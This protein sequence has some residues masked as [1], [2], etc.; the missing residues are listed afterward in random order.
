MD[1]CAEH[2]YIDPPT[3][4]YAIGRADSACIWWTPKDGTLNDTVA[5]EIH[6]FRCDGGEWKFKGIVNAEAL[7]KTQFVVRNLS[8]NKQYKFS[9]KAV[10]DKGVGFKM[11]VMSNAVMVEQALPAGWFRFYSDKKKKF[12]YANVRTK[13]SS[14]ERPGIFVCVLSCL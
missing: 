10:S 11:S 13:Q 14:W 4:V 12:Y 2:Y 9:L 5:W 3:A 7:D 1:N 6:R 8:E